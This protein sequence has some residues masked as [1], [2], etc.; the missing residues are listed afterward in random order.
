MKYFIVSDIHGF[1]TELKESLNAAKY[2]KRNKN[3]TL[4]ILGDLFDRGSEAVELYEFLMTI[5][6]SRLI[7]VRGNHELLFNKLLDKGYPDEHDFTNGTVG[8]FCQIAGEP[9]FGVEYLYAVDEFDGPSNEQIAHWVKVRDAVKNSDIN[10][11]LQDDKRWKW[12][13]E[14]DKYVGVH[15]TIPNTTD[16]LLADTDWRKAHDK[17]WAECTWPKP[18]VAHNR[19]SGKTIIAGHWNTNSLFKDYYGEE[20]KPIYNEIY[21]NSKEHLICIDAGCFR[22]LNYIL[23]D[24]ELIHKQLVL[25]IDTESP[26]YIVNQCGFPVVD[27][28]R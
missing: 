2:N 7:L 25:V 24:F 5:P 14:T 17:V 4:V 20:H 28:C 1:Y 3:H 26:N 16:G 8:T 6:K 23:M 18:T 12:F 19:V 11:F 21:Y 22:K 13:F 10:K 15:S 9:I 27:I